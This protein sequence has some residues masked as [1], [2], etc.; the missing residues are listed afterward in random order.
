MKLLLS[1]PRGI[2]FP[3]LVK[4]KPAITRI[5]TAGLLCLAA[6]LSAHASGIYGTLSNFDIYNTTSE[7]SEGAEIELE[8]IH[9]SDIGGDFPCHYGMKSILEYNDNLGQFAGTRITYTGYNFPGAP[10]P[11]S[12][13]PNPNPVS[14]NGHELTYTDGGEHFGFWLSGAQPTA[15]RFFWLNNNGSTYDRIGALPETV[16]GPTWTYVPPANVGDPP[17]LQIAVK[18][19]E[20]ADAPNLRPDS[21]WMK[22][23]KTKLKIAPDNDQEM[24]ELLALLISGDPNDPGYAN[25]VPQGDDPIEVESEWELLEGGKKPKEKMREDEVAESD[26]VV[27]RR[28]EFYKYVGPVNEDN[29]PISVWEDIGNPD[30]PGLDVFDGDGNLIFASERGDFISANMVAAVIGPAVPEPASLS[31]AVM[32]LAVLALRRRGD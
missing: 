9:P 15:T 31:L 27:I 11:G 25:I 28:Y 6:N 23:F 19:P 4:W 29:E 20:P 12:L 10:M 14:T 16:P 21:T 7:P 30:D 5:A 13:L 3:S 18:V 32:S 22:I 24:Q 8:G 2:G 17:A 1:T 26:K